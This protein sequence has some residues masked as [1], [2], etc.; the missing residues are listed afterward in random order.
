MWTWLIDDR[1]IRLSN[2]TWQLVIYLEKRAKRVNIFRSL[3]L[4]WKETNIY[5]DFQLF[6]GKLS[7]STQF[8]I[9]TEI[10]HVSG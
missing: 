1:T 2:R 10:S 6:L 9:L 4:E 3:L 8:E 7:A 5:E